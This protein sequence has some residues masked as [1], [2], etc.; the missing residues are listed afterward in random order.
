MAHGALVLNAMIFHMAEDIGPISAI[1]MLE[2]AKYLFLVS[3]A[4]ISF[5]SKCKEEEWLEGVQCVE[6]TPTIDKSILKGRHVY[7]FVPPP[8]SSLPLKLRLHSLRFS[9]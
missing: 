1:F 3:G 6:W 4:I 8:I 2:Q 5:L 9:R 7:C